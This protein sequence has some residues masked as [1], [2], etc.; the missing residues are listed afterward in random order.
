[1]AQPRVSLPYQT[2]V[3]ALFTTMFKIL[4][5]YQF[6]ITLLILKYNKKHPQDHGPA[7][8]VIP[9]RLARPN[10]LACSNNDYFNLEKLPLSRNLRKYF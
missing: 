10:I 3:A 1:L 2:S 8:V 4:L 9:L 5:A 7:G 6:P